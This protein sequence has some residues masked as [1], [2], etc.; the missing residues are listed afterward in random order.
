MEDIEG[1]AIA[2]DISNGEIRAVVGS[3]TSS[4]GFNRSINAIRPIGS[5]V[6]P[7][8]ILLLWINMKTT[9]LIQFLMIPN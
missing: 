1:A 5:L 6:K 3:I 7:L 4:Y 8:F 9:L 2:V